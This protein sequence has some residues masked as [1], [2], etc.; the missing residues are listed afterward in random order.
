M[1]QPAPRVDGRAPSQ[2]RTITFE[3]NIA[4]YATGS[5]LVGVSPLWGLLAFTLAAALAF[6]HDFA[7]QNQMIHFLKNVAIVGGLLQVAAFGAGS[8]SIDGLR[9]KGNRRAASPA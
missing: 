3:A 8:F 5:V 2:L 9:V 1:T 4:P 6:H 7:D